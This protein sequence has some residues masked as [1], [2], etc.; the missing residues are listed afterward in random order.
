MGVSP[1]LPGFISGTNFIVIL[2]NDEIIAAAGLFSL[3]QRTPFFFF[4][5]INSGSDYRLPAKFISAACNPIKGSAFTLGMG[6]AHRSP[7]CLNR[8]FT[9]LC[10]VGDKGKAIF[11]E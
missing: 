1:L 11:L 10:S 3:L 8:V 2:M 7:R 4:F 5:S 6:S 9:F